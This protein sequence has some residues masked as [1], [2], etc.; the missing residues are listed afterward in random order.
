MKPKLLLAL[1]IPSFL[2]GCGNQS[3]GK[4]PIDPS[5]DTF[6]FTVDFTVAEETNTKDENNF[7]SKFSSNFVYEEEQLISDL[8]YSGFSQINHVEQETQNATWTERA[9]M[10]GSQNEMGKLQFIF[11]HKL[12]SVLFIAR[13]HMKLYKSGST[14]GVSADTNSKLFINDAEWLLENRSIS[15]YGVDD[16]EFEIDSDKLTINTLN[17]GKKRAWIFS[18]NFV[19]EK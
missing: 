7:V 16:K 2:I 5:L 12:V 8:K 11:T 10:F 3:G 14:Y 13:T 6:E 19:F 9:L 4:D 17:E 15:D 1:I 18:A